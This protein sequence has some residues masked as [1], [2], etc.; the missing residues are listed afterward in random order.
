LLIVLL[1]SEKFFPSCFS[2][3]IPVLKKTKKK[4]LVSYY[5]VYTI[6][7]QLQT[8]IHSLLQRQAW[9]WWHR[10]NPK[11][12]RWEREREREREREWRVIR[13]DCSIIIAAMK[14]KNTNFWREGREIPEEEGARVEREA[15]LW[16][17]LVLL[18]LSDSSSS[19]NRRVSCVASGGVERREYRKQKTS[20]QRPIITLKT[21]SATIANAVAATTT[22]K[23][24]H[25]H[26]PVCSSCC[27]EY[28]FVAISSMLFCFSSGLFVVVLCVFF[29]FC[30]SQ[31]FERW[32]SSSA[33]IVV[34]VVVTVFL[35]LQLLLLLQCSFAA[36]V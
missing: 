12:K 8:E 13:F 18:L 10:T 1:Q 26:K 31:G 15:S 3:L 7:S 24:H 17:L 29:L 30:L 9:R 36:A 11:Q 6:D 14:K 35:D 27:S 33:A 5:L 16:F 19:A 20:Q 34:V 2:L 4:P 28:V 23:Q 25:H 22:A 32:C 21:K